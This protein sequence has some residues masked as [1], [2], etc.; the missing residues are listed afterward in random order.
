MS[1]VVVVLHAIGSDKVVVGVIRSYLP[2][3]ASLSAAA[4]THSP[5]SLDKYLFTSARV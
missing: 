4:G 5:E 2:V 3:G 1:V